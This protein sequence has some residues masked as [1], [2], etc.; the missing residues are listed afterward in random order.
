MVVYLN[1][2]DPD[3]NKCPSSWQI[4]PLLVIS[5]YRHNIIYGNRTIPISSL[6]RT[7]IKSWQKCKNDLKFQSRTLCEM[8]KWTCSNVKLNIFCYDPNMCLLWSPFS[9]IF[10]HYYTFKVS[11][12][13]NLIIVL[14]TFCLRRF[15][16]NYLIQ[17]NSNKIRVTCT[18]FRF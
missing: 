3:Q 11:W 10:T 15:R 7:N 14:C 18:R 1:Q 5:Y 16:N 9:D 12:P 4:P 17:W 6:F 13:K 8:I 2:I